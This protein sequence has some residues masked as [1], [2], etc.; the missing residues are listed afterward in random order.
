MILLTAE[1]KSVTEC[2]QQ[3]FKMAAFALDA[4]SGPFQRTYRNGVGCPTI[5][6]ALVHIPERQCNVAH[7][8]LCLFVTLPAEVY[9]QA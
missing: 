2:W 8:P 6:M 5:V 1:D 4:Q 3:V 9:R 7:Q